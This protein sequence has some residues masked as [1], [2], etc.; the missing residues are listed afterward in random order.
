M[1]LSIPGRRNQPDAVQ[2]VSEGRGCGLAPRYQRNGAEQSRAEAASSSTVQAKTR[3][4]RVL[5][6]RTNKLPTDEMVR[7][8]RSRL[9]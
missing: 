7:E 1:R 6:K 3:W 9:S 4:K 5:A 2:I 8:G